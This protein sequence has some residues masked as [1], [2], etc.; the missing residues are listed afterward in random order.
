MPAFGIALWGAFLSMLGTVVGRVL[1]SL[2]I[3]YVSYQGIDTLVGAAKAQLL[4]AISAQGAV[5][6]QLAGVLQIG[7]CINIMA[8]SALARITVA[9]LT[10]GKLTKM[11]VR[12]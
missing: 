2:F 10:S 5:A 6:V 12:K 9:G 3:A 8:S 7:T 4:A 11:I 1:T